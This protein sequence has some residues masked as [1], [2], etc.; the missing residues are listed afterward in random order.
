MMRVLL[1]LALLGLFPSPGR[2]D[3][4]VNGAPVSTA[5]GGQSGPRAVSDGAG[6]A[7]AVWLDSRTGFPNVYAQRVDAAGNALWTPNGRAICTAAGFQ[8][9]PVIVS[10]GAGGA[11]IAWSD[12]RV[13]GDP[14][15]YAQRV[16]EFGDPQWTLNG[17]P[18][19]VFT[20]NQRAPTICTDGAGGGIISWQDDRGLTQY[21]IYSQ[22]L[23]ASGV[24]QWT[25]N[26]V[27]LVRGNFDQVFAVSVSNGTGGAIVAWADLRNGSNYDVYFRPISSTGIPYST[28]GGVPACAA[29]GDQER[30][31]IAS[32]GPDGGAII[33]WNDTRSGTNWDVYAQ[34]VTNS[35]GVLW[36][37][38]GV[39]VSNVAGN[40]WDPEI[41]SDGAGGVIV[42]WG[43]VRGTNSDI[44]AQRI[45]GQGA[46]LWA[47]DGL[48]ICT[49]SDDQMKPALV[50]DEQGGAIIAWEDRRPG[51]TIDLYAQRVDAFGTLQWPLSG[52]HVTGAPGDQTAPTVVPDGTGNAIVA[53]TD[54]RGGSV[55]A[56]IYAQRM[57]GRYGE[58]GH[59]EP[60]T[61]AIDDYPA[62]Q[63]G[64]VIVHWK[65][66]QRDRVLD[67]LVAYYSI[68]RSTDASTPAGPSLP[69]M[70]I[71]DPVAVGPDFEGPGLWIETT[72]AG[73]TYWEWIANQPAS[74]QTSYSAVAP[75]R[76][77]STAGDPATHTFKVLAHESTVMPSRIWESNEAS[78]HSTDDL[79]PGA[80]L[81]LVAER[82]GPDVYLHW[83][84]VGDA[85]LRDY[86]IYRSVSPGVL[87]G[88]ATWVGSAADAAMLDSPAPLSALYY[89]VAAND[90][91]GNQGAP[92]NEAEAVSLLDTDRSAPA[93]PALSLRPNH[94]NPF[95]RAT[96]I[97]F[98]LPRASEVKVRIH[99]IHGRRLRALSIRAVA[100]W[101]RIPLQA[102]DDAGAPLASG[103]YLYSVSS[104][105]ST[106]RGKMIVAR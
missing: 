31:R 32:D 37:S 89:V 1:A 34:H 27:E 13:Q 91:H 84:P 70:T 17:V 51:T 52:A 73:A 85:D 82:V 26:G 22:R 86:A 2:A 83:T 64:Q 92:S 66:S 55:Q 75:T 104:A 95:S 16:N 7:I 81:G 21:D 20:K 71:V 93:P 3:W 48:P 40:Q 14:D 23:N 29:S 103:V 102:V 50:S 19:C 12:E 79:A 58:W 35:G 42:A 49:V 61:D 39:A 36:T 72:A 53:W 76:A 41:A 94:P 45:N 44:Y 9:G 77:D 18:V 74:Y 67:P 5:A 15:I 88:P 80:P 97:R 60:V 11:I 10:D 96:T 24:A 63:G 100:G 69:G 62:D 30:V 47:E 46:P 6:G 28:Q 87:P 101:Q 38:N 4:Q 98:G 99:D 54:Q 105:G 90:V 33:V 57:E 43:D 56:D 78:G 25:A 68:W 59:P 106:V 65:A 8:T